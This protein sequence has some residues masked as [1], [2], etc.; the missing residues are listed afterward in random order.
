MNRFEGNDFK[1]KWFFATDGQMLSETLAFNTSLFTLHEKIDTL[2][3]NQGYALSNEISQI[4]GTMQ[5]FDQYGRL[6]QVAV[7]GIVN[8]FTYGYL[9]GSH[10]QKTLAMPNGVTRTFGYEANRDL[11]TL[12]VHSNATERLVQRDFTFD[13]LARLQNRTLFRANETSVIPD[14]FGYNLRSELTNALIGANAFSYAFDPIGNRNS[15]TE[16]GTNTAYAA[17]ALNQYSSLQPKYLQPI[18]LSYDF[19]GNQLM[20]RTSTGIWHVTYNAENRPILF[21]NATTKVEMA[22]DYMGRRFEYKEI[23]S[24]TIN[25]HERYLYRGYLQ[26]AALDMLT[27]ASVKHSITWDPSEPTA[28][29]PLCLSLPTA[30]SQ[31][32]TVYYSFDQVKNV[33]ELFNSTGAID[34]TYDYSPFGQITS[35]LSVG[36]ST[37]SV[38]SNP[39]TF[40]SEVSDST[41]GLQYYNYRHL[42]TL[43]GRWVNRDPIGE[44]GCVNL[45]NFCMNKSF[46]QTDLLGM[47]SSISWDNDKSIRLSAFFQIGRTILDFFNG[48]PSV[49]Y[50]FEYPDSVTK[51][52]LS[53]SKVKP[54]WKD[55][56]E[57]SRADFGKEKHYA[58]THVASKLDFVVDMATSWGI[59]IIG[60]P[61]IPDFRNFRYLDVGVRAIGSFGGIATISIKSKGNRCVKELDMTLSDELSVESLTRNPFT[62]ESLIKED[63]LSRVYIKAHY[64]VEEKIGPVWE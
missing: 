18:T 10:L 13:G 62:R 25:R 22:Y 64:L 61:L 29:R 58:I 39:L 53:H 50:N 35:A 30:N 11:L 15:A 27:S 56:K 41:L 5:N 55:F 52:F 48:G 17:N 43:D 7:D 33:T 28:T 24:G 31:Q 26:I 54:I 23:V 38:A 47:M 42:N 60:F 9:E 57:T 59:N 51:R 2:G 63:Y 3:R 19:D 44:E 45:Y 12:I 40:S 37:L 6:N 16:F 34:A 8:A 4:T 21:S 20:L 1:L 14:A 46:N 32:L 49:T 36:S